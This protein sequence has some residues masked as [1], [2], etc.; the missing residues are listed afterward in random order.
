MQVKRLFNLSVVAVVLALSLTIVHSAFATPNG[1]VTTLTLDQNQSVVELSIDGNVAI[2][3]L[4]ITLDLTKEE[5]ISFIPDNGLNLELTNLLNTEYGLVIQLV[6]DGLT[7]EDSSFK[8]GILTTPMN[9][10]VSVVRFLG[11]HAATNTLHT[12][13][14]EELIPVD[15]SNFGIFEVEYVAAEESVTD[16]FDTPVM[17]ETWSNI[18]RI[19]K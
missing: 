3:A 2:G 17:G 10:P 15:G 5:W 19:Y 14:F 7:G 18:K 1:E 8:V 13:L 16:V 12:L 9:E 6:G 4:Q 11:T